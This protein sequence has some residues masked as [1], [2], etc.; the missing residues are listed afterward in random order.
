MHQ[1]VIV[2]EVTIEMLPEDE[3]LVRS[4]R[5][6]LEFAGDAVCAVRSIASLEMG[7]L[8]TRAGG[9]ICHSVT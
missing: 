2:R 4:M 6:V 9:R 5:R 3:D 8:G 1:S 7:L